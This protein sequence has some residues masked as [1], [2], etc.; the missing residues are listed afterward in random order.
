MDDDLEGLAGGESEIGN[1]PEAAGLRVLKGDRVR[2]PFRDDRTA[3]GLER[4]EL[5]FL[6]EAILGF[7]RIR[8]QHG[9]QEGQET[10]Q[11]EAGGPERGRQA[12]HADTGG[13]GG[14]DLVITVHRR[15]DEDDRDQQGDRNEH[16]QVLDQAEEHELQNRTERRAPTQEVGNPVIT[17]GKQQQPH[18]AEQRQGE[19]LGPFGEDIA[20]KDAHCPE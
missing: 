4:G 17:R 7:Q 5:G 18:E 11:E 12:P 6:D 8:D 14:G 10:S 9:I 15:E 13:A 1:E 3:F 2:L 16:R 19:D 20:I